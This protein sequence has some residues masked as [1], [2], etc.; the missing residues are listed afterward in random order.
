MFR[1][2]A[3]AACLATPVAAVELVEFGVICDVAITGERPAPLTESGKM[4]LIDQQ[5][6]FDVISTSVP[7]KLGLSFGIRIA[8]DPESTSTGTRVVVTHPSLGASRTTTQ[9]WPTALEPGGRSLNLF[10]FE[11]GYE[12][13]QGRWT[14][15]VIDDSGKRVEQAF[16]VLPESSV[17]QVQAVCFDDALLS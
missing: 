6:G 8:L 9:S 3:L 15:A 14:F 12:M 13:V 16:D 4:N 17:P 11:H 5:R 7:A 2:F 1:L 10:T